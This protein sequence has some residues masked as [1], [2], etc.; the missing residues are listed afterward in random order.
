MAPRA[1]LSRRRVHVGT[2]RALAQRLRIELREPEVDALIH[3]GLMEHDTRNDR[4]AVL[5]A[6]YNHLNRTLRPAP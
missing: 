3:E 2:P 1:V 6:L 4:N 5:K